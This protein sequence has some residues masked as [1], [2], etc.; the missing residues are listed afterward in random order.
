MT[1]PTREIADM[2]RAQL[3]QEMN[4]AADPHFTIEEVEVSSRRGMGEPAICL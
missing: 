4:G 2:K 1:V 3:H